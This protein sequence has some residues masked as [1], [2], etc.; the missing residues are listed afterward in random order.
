MLTRSV[1]GSG[2]KHKSTLRPRRSVGLRP[3]SDIGAA[4]SLISAICILS[5]LTPGGKA[6]LPTS[7]DE[8]LSVWTQP[9]NRALVLSL[10]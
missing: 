4:A 9:T 5:C 7:A 6:V 3:A 1:G 8:G 10:L 2:C